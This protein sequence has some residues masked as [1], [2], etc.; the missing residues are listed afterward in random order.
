MSRLQERLCQESQA[1]EHAK[2]CMSHAPKAQE[3]VLVEK[4]R[5]EID[6]GP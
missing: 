1:K 6:S 3:S 4:Y 2:A 5:E